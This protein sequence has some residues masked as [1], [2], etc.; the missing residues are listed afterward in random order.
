MLKKSILIL[1]MA[2]FVFSFI[3]VAAVSAE[4]S[5]KITG[6][7][8]FFNPDTGELTIKDDSGDAKKLKAGPDIDLES[9]RN[10]KQGDSINVEYDSQG[11]IT[12]LVTK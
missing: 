8:D 1:V 9:L 6:T 5:Q 7:V 12:S 11:V 3:A 4:E 10:L 2:L